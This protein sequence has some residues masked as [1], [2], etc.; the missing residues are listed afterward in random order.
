MNLTTS[1]YIYFRLFTALA[2]TANGLFEA[3][4]SN[5]K[6]ESSVEKTFVHYIGIISTFSNP[7]TAPVGYY[8]RYKDSN[9]VKE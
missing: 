5:Y 6:S 3:V 1:H 9:E 2:F 4:R 8:L 7:V